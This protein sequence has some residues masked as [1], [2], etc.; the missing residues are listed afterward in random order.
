[1]VAVFALGCVTT[2]LWGAPAETAEAKR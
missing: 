1:V 2:Y